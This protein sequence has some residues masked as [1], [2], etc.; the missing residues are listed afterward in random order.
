MERRGFGK[1]LEWVT[2]RFGI[3]E[4]ADFLRPWIGAMRCIMSVLALESLT[5]KE[6]RLPR[7]QED[8]EVVE[9]AGAWPESGS[10]LD[11]P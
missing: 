2:K 10:W 6:E 1:R 7:V 11:G 4:R 3:E 9:S 5:S 8:A